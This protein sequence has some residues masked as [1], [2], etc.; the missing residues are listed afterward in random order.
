[1]PTALS[2]P[3]TALYTILAAI[4]LVLGIIALRR[5]KRSDLINFAIPAVAL[6]ALFIIDRMVESPREQIVKNIEEMETATQTKKLDDV[7]KHVSDKFEYKSLDKKGL[8]DKAAMAESVPNWQGIKVPDDS[9][10]RD[11][12]VQK[13][14]TAE[15]KFDVMPLGFPGN[16]YRYECIAT[17][18]NEGGQW[19]LTGCKF[20]KD[21]Q[22]VTPPG[23]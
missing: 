11:G 9:I 3:T 21:G 6:I 19:R 10:K 16:E 23:L 8:R 22:E 18:K 2:D 14:D 7:F 15:Q 17:F 12:F 4:T 13:G 1:M 20:M 5:Q